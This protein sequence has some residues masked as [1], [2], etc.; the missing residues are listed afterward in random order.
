M[1]IMV[2]LKQT[3]DTEAKIKLNADQSAVD[4]AGMK[5]VINPYDEHAVEEALQLKAKKGAGEVVV[6]SFAK[7]SV[8]ESLLKALAMGADRAVHIDNSSLK[9][10]DSLTIAKI[11]TQV[12]KKEEPEIIFCGRHAI[13]DDN[14]HVPVM[15][16]EFLSWPHVNVVA[17]VEYNDAS[18]KVSREVEGGQVETYHV[19]TPVVIGAHKSLNT[20]RYASLPGIMKAKRK[21]F[22]KLSLEELDL[23]VEELS[24]GVQTQIK[25]FNYPPE[26]PKG[27]ILKGESLELMVDKVVTYLKN[28]AKVL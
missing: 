21:P 19:K 2:L 15:V 17:K 10:A 25:K 24:Q 16:A 1:K 9:N 23:N 20:P 3:P 12:V 11:L 18:L 28:E 6:V 26:K 8:K 4:E 22:Q 13:D 14:M 27:K 7:D 5:F